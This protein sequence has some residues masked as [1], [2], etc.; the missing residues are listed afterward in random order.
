MQHN[1]IR[2]FI[3][4]LFGC[5]TLSVYSQTVIISN[6][7]HLPEDTVVRSQLINSLNGFLKHK[8]K[9]NKDNTYVLNENLLATS[10]LLDEMKG[11]E[12][13]AAFKD[14][15]PYKAYLTNLVG[16]GSGSL[17]VQLAYMGIKDGQP[18]L[19]ANFKL[20]AQKKG[21]QFYFSSPLK[22][23]THSWKSKKKGTL[24][25]YY[26]DTLSAVDA[27]EYYKKVQ[28]YNKKLKAPDELTDI[29]YC[30]N[31]TEAQ[32][33]LGV[34]YRLEYN[35][36]P[37]DILATKENNKNLMLN[38][39]TDLKYRFD[40]HDLWH[41][42][43]RAVVS[44]DVINRPV[45][46]GCAYLYGG[47]WGFTWPELQTKFKA[48]IAEHPDADWLK[49]YLD[50]ANFSPA[51]KTLRVSFMLN[52]LIVRKIEAE[53]GFPAVIQLLSCGKKEAGDENYFKALD[54]IVGINKGN[55]NEKMGELTKGM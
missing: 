9:P 23:Y 51:P 31:F 35:G 27:D 21:N 12:Q 36:I 25:F 24:T 14:P 38:A 40:P 6:N 55:F 15:A 50:A 48:Y 32:Q 11:M 1:L 4:V 7:L 44:S 42:R 28:F 54:Q 33:I 46:E 16:D 39:W 18:V 13:N 37:N 19:R 26:K 22:M 47:S 41:E 10:A 52:A 3:A 53:K 2:L 29:Y 20:L 49:L 30:D 8:E 17:I 34:D 5:L 43:L 45:D